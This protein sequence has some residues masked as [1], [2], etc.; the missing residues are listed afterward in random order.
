MILWDGHAPE[1]SNIHCEMVSCSKLPPRT[2][3]VFAPPKNGDYFDGEKHLNQPLIFT[4]MLG[5]H[6]VSSSLLFF[7]LGGVG[8]PLQRVVLHHGVNPFRK[9]WILRDVVYLTFISNHF[10]RTT[11]FRLSTISYPAV[12]PFTK[13]GISATF[14]CIQ[15]LLVINGVISYIAPINGLIKGVTRVLTPI[16]WSLF[17]PI[18]SC[19]F[20]GP[21]LQD[22]TELHQRFV[23]DFEGRLEVRSCGGRYLLCGL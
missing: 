8:G 20:G 10:V 13:Q 15:P 21:T 2:S 1:E 9:R 4:R 5:C 16:K 17:H 6:E 7:F 19:Y 22:W 14:F 11:P 12:H 3:S 23:S 18:Y